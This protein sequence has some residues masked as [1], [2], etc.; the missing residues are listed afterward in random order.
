MSGYLRVWRMLNFIK[1]TEE[2]VLRKNNL[3]LIVVIKVASG[4]TY[5]LLSL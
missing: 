2:F 3:W 4:V 5:A 1:F